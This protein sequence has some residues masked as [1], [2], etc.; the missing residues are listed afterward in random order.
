MTMQCQIWQVRGLPKPASRPGVD[1]DRRLGDGAQAGGARNGGVGKASATPDFAWGR[2]P[3]AHRDEAD[4][5]PRIIPGFCVRGGDVRFSRVAGGARMDRLASL[6]EALM[7]RTLDARGLADRIDVARRRRRRRSR[8]M[9]Q[10]LKRP[11]DRTRLLEV[12]KHP[13]A[14]G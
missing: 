14:N 10:D 11:H 3:R 6:V 7:E 9:H 2:A 8:P 5:G 13:D 4:H 1:G 12:K